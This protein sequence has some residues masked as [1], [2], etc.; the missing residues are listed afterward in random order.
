MLEQSEINTE[1]LIKSETPKSREEW[2]ELVEAC[3]S[4]GETRQEF[5]GKRSLRY[6]RFRY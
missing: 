2:R 5:C 3:Q 1:G 6:K 4:S